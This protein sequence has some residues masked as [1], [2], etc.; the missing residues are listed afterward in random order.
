MERKEL[1]NKIGNIRNW[2]NLNM[3][4]DEPTHKYY[5][6]GKNYPSVSG[7]VNELRTEEEKEKFNSPEFQEFLKPYAEFGTYIHKETEKYDRGIKLEPTDYE[8]KEWIALE[9]YETLTNKLKDNGFEIMAIELP[10]FVDDYG[11]CGTIDRLFYNEE[12]KKVMLVDI[13]TGSTREAHWQQQLIYSELLLQWGI[14][15]DSIGLVSLKLKN[16]IPT[17]KGLKDLVKDKLVEQ[18]NKLLNDKKKE[19]RG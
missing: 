5:V 13:K 16:K 19:E 1:N 3:M 6:N 9:R 7:F 18:V 17:F 15:V 14:K 4:F 8:E 11:V 12:T 2:N 10:I